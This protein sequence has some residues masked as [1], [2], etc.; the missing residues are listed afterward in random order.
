MVEEST[1][2]RRS[3]SRQASKEEEA[4]ET[5]GSEADDEGAMGRIRV[6][7]LRPSIRTKPFE[8]KATAESR[9]KDGW[10]GSP[11]EGRASPPTLISTEFTRPERWRVWE[12]SHAINCFPRSSLGSVPFKDTFA[13]WSESSIPPA[14]IEVPEGIAFTRASERCDCGPAISPSSIWVSTRRVGYQRGSATRESPVAERNIS[15]TSS[16]DAVN[17]A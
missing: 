9:S 8:F 6:E 1:R 17:D 15:E 11:E 14:E 4:G 16:C 5:A 12:I 2:T 13:T 3:S 10:E 7:T